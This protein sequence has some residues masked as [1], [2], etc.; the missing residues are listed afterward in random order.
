MNLYAVTLV[1]FSGKRITVQQAAP[2]PGNASNEA[3]MRNGAIYACD[4]RFCGAL[5]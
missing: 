2:N 1:F 5:S 3:V 4:V